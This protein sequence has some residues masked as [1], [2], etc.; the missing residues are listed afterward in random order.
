MP[1]PQKT[2]NEIL[3]R[4]AAY[5]AEQ[6][7]KMREVFT[8]A[9]EMVDE[10]RAAGFSPRVIYAEQDGQKLDRRGR[11]WEYPATDGGGTGKKLKEKRRRVI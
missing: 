6:A 2:A 9:A 10:L 1:S 4:N 8:F 7:K 3:E 5:R 11:E